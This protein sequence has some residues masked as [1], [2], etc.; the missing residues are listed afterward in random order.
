M[1]KK[2]LLRSIA[3]ATAL[4]SVLAVSLVA[5]PAVVT[6]APEIRNVACSLP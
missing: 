5:T 2:V 3:G 4:G 1:F 6:S